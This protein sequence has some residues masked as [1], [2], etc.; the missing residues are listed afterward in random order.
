[1]SALLDCG[2]WKLHRNKKP[3]YCNYLTKS[4]TSAHKTYI[5]L[6][7]GIWLVKT[8]LYSRVKRELI[9]GYFIFDASSY[10]KSS[11]QIKRSENVECA[12]VVFRSALRNWNTEDSWSGRGLEIKILVVLQTSRFQKS[13]R[14]SGFT[15]IG[16][17][18]FLWLA[19]KR[20]HSTNNWLVWYYR[21]KGILIGW[22]ANL[23]AC[24][25]QG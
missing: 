9:K 17:T 23:I 22:F 15:S 6:G 5:A 4:R 3:L 20:K 2:L 19:V 7:R 25:W 11:H 14:L 1:L 10:A 16:F 8:F 13:I 18:T 21:H 12:R 24:F